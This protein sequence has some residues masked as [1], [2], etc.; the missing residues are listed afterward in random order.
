MSEFASA[1]ESHGSI[2]SGPAIRLA[3]LPAGSL[4]AFDQRVESNALS[5]GQIRRCWGL[6]RRSR[7]PNNF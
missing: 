5:E 4:M 2:P 7:G 6:E 1:N 3:Y